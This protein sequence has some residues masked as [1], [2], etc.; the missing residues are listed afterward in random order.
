MTPKLFVDIVFDHQKLIDDYI[1]SKIGEDNFDR[2][3]D[4][5]DR[6]EGDTNTTDV[7]F[8]L[9]VADDMP[10]E[11]LFYYCR[12][13]YLMSDE[14]REMIDGRKD[15]LRRVADLREMAVDGINGPKDKK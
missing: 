12:H 13:L 3:Q 2:F 9:S 11:I 10:D 7:A 1:C 5:I 6:G 14:F 15:L 8:F 4:I